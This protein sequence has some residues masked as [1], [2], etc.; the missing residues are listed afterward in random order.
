METL[1]SA[2]SHCGISVQLPSYHKLLEAKKRCYPDARDI[3]I[4][5]DGVKV[6]L[7][8][9]LDVTTQRI[10]QVVGD[11]LNI[12]SGSLKLMPIHPCR[13]MISSTFFFTFKFPGMLILQEINI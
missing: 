6:N 9:L 10:L 5:E 12:S 7:Q 11:E 1:R 3:E 13:A 2:L 4:S 8:A